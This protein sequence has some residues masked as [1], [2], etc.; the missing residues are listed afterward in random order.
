MPALTP[1]GIVSGVVAVLLDP[2][3]SAGTSR[4]PICVSVASINRFDDR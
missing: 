2:A 3:V 4:V 1:E